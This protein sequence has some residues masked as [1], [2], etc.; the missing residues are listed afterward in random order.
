[1][2][3]RLPQGHGDTPDSLLEHIQPEAMTTADELADPAEQVLG[4]DERQRAEEA[5]ALGKRGMTLAETGHHD[6]ALV[7]I[8]GAVTLY[9][10]L[11][12][13]NPDTFLPHL[14]GT[15]NNLG[16]LLAETGN[17]DEALPATHEAVTLYRQLAHTNP[18]TFLPHLAGT[19]NN[20]GNLLAETGNHDEALPATHEAVTLYRQLA[21]TN[22]DMFLPDLAGA[23]NNLGVML[24]EVDLREEAL[25]PSGEAPD[26]YRKLT[27]SK[28][29]AF[30][31]DLAGS[32]TNLGDLLVELDRRDE[33]LGV[34]ERAWT[35]L[36]TGPLVEL[37]VTRAQWRAAHD[38][39]AGK[40]EDLLAAVETTNA[41]ERAD[42]SARARRAIRRSLTSLVGTEHEDA[43]RNAP[44]WATCELPDDVIN[45]V[46]RTAATSTWKEAAELLRSTDAA[47]VL[48]PEVQ[49][50][51]VAL[52]ALFADRPAIVKVLRVLDTA[53]EQGLDTVLDKLCAGEKHAR[54]LEGW[55]ITP[56]WETSRQYLIDHPELLTDPRTR[57]AL[58]DE[59]NPRIR[60]F[61]AIVRLATDAGMS[62]DEI[63]GIVINVDQAAD[64]MLAAI[65]ARDHD[66]VIVLWHASPHL[67]RRPFVGAYAATVLAVWNN[68]LDEA[69][70]AAAAA[71]NYAT[72]TDRDSGIERLL[73][74]AVVQPEHAP[75][76]REVADLLAT[77]SEPTSADEQDPGEQ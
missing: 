48:E 35:G 28:P 6:E 13:S 58:D 46:E 62:L 37:M 30:L 26:L 22:P 40:V 2:S 54:L 10:Q 17:H 12:D 5:A 3:N 65:E 20:L 51:R 29:E 63:Y 73:K 39:I 56:T 38:D 24:W 43:L 70:T 23:L 67:Q 31:P 21:H 55:L 18:D 57:E 61:A 15:L 8:R 11:A 60:Q 34:F 71:A 7:P 53:D 16:N 25:A 36:D 76:L 77:P 19:L 33:A 1:M 45:L 52:A 50:V 32:L 42:R 74:L 66:R 27:E 9:R 44:E 72:D 68:E 69:R 75:A 64:A 41:E 4:D 47:R 14:A 49:P 59:D